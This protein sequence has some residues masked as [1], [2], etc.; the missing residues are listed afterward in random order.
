[1]SKWNAI[2]SGRR[3]W[4]ALHDLSRRWCLGVGAGPARR[5]AANGCSPGAYRARQIIAERPADAA[6]MGTRL[7]LGG[8]HIRINSPKHCS[9][10]IPL[11]IPCRAQKI[12]LPDDRQIKSVECFNYLIIM[13]LSAP[14]AIN[15]E[16]RCD[17]SAYFPCRQGR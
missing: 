17:A 10:K 1:M 4:A 16:P 6:W 3:A 8:N 5:V 7:Q 9:L 12:P 2:A 13:E 14:T 15:F 11:P